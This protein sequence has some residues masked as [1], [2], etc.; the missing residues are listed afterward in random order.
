MRGREKRAKKGR[1][2]G[3]GVEYEEGEKSMRKRRR[4]H[5]RRMYGWKEVEK[6]AR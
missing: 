5:G 4:M 6:N 1:I 3:R 2:R